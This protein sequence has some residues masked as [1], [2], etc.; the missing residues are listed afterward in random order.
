MTG[1]ADPRRGLG[2][3]G[4]RGRTGEAAGITLV[5]IAR[6]RRFRGLHPPRAHR[7]GRRRA[8]SP[9]KLVYMANQIGKFFVTEDKADAVA[10]SPIT[11][12]SSG[13]RACA[14]RSSPIMDRR[15]GSRPA[16]EGSGSPASPGRGGGARVSGGLIRRSAVSSSF[17]LPRT[18]RRRRGR[19]GGGPPRRRRRARSTTSAK[20]LLRWP[21]STGVSTAPAV[22]DPNTCHSS[23]RRKSAP[24]GTR[25]TSSPCQVGMW[26]MTR[27]S[28]PSALP[29]L[30][31][32]RRCRATASTRCSSMPSAETLV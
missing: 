4:A 12:R 9:D 30:V 22:D 15:R 31:R 23:P 10:A 25:T 27:N 28:W 20:W 16:G 32:D 13:I 11:S 24:S 14:P 5:A 19:S 26:T 7:S 6:E 29:R 8:M 18:R 17:A 1:C 21:I 2:A 3:D